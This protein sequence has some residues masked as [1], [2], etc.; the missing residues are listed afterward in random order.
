MRHYQW[1]KGKWVFIDWTGIWAGYGTDQQGRNLPHGFLMPYG[2]ELRAHK[3]HVEPTPVLVADQPW[4]FEVAGGTLLAD[5]GRFRWWYHVVLNPNDVALGYAESQD[6]VHWTK[7]ALGLKAHAGSKATN[8]VAL[9]SWGGRE[10]G[11]E[12]FIDPSA[13]PAERYKIVSCNEHVDPFAL[14]GAVSPDGLRWTQFSKEQP[15]I[16]NRCDTVNVGLYDEELGKYVIY[17]RQKDNQP[18]RRGINRA[19]SADFRHFPPSEPIFESSPLDPPDWDFYTSGY[20]RW[21][22]AADAHLMRFSTYQRTQDIVN[23]HLAVSRDGKTWHRPMGSE[24]WI[25]GGLSSHTPYKCHYAC[26]GILPTA[27]GEWSSYIGFYSEGHNHQGKRTPGKIL[28]AVSRE[29]GFMSLTARDRGEFYTLPFTLE[30]DS[31]RLN[32]R[33]G[34][35]G[36]VRCALLA[37][38]GGTPDSTVMTAEHPVP[39]YRGF[40]LEDCAVL[41]GDHIDIPLTWKEDLRRLRG[42]RVQLHFDLFNA[43]LFAVK[44]CES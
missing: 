36:Y 6:G 12:V 17:C 43:D 19:E 44:F 14:F 13:P 8:L 7:P 21:P 1:G 34:C 33:T 42:K 26:T 37:A 39:V 24:P 41:K 10:Q 38:D 4:E 18:G 40:T 23:I 35:S 32:V 27:P 16:K 31:I 25:G 20:Q 28:R 30:A 9:E 3:P 5:Q 15:I 22:G 11:H 29:D 2:I